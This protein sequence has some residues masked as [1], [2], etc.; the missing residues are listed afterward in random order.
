[1]Q[2]T[3]PQSST[4]IVSSGRGAW[5]ASIGFLIF[6]LVLSGA[7]YA[8]VFF[9][10]RSTAKV[11]AEVARINGEIQ[12][13]SKDSKIVIA[14]IVSESG[15]RPSIDLKNIVTQFRLAAIQANVEF[16]GFSIKDDVISTQLTST[17]GTDTHPDAIGTIIAMMN[18]YNAWEQVFS[19]GDINSVTW[20]TGRRTTTIELKVLATPIQ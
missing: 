11:E 18:K 16:D 9:T 12:K 1:M 3:T 17:T 15:I 5:Y 10:E 14:K 8:G 13:A 2:E 20:E 19:L 6:V 4:A 7:L